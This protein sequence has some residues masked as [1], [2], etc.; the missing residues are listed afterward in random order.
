MSDW[1]TETERRL[2]VVGSCDVAVVGGGI[3]GVA[4]AVAAARNGAKVCL[5]EKESALGGLATLGNVIVYLPLCDG[6]GH[7]VIAGLREELLKLCVRDGYDEIPA[8][9]QRGGPREEREKKRYRVRF[10]PMSYLLALEELVVAS[11]VD[12]HYDTRFCDVQTVAGR[13]NALMVENKS[14]RQALR[15][16]T[17]VDASGDADVCARA[18]ED[19]VSLRT[20]VESAWFFCYDGAEVTLKPLSKSFP[21]DPR[22]A[23]GD[24]RGYA[25]DV[26]ADVT[27]HLLSSRALVRLQLRELQ[28]ASEGK[29]I[30]PLLLP[31]IAS[32]RMTRRLAGRVALAREHERRYFEDTVGMC[33]DWRRPGPIYYLPL[34]SLVGAKHCNLLAAGRC[35]SACGPAWD[36]TRAI[37]VC[38]ATGEAAGT[39][40]ALAARDCGGDVMT[41]DTAQL[42]AQLRRQGVIIDRRFAHRA[43]G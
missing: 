41:L 24:S 37:P 3:A 34:R 5:L 1:I 9:W 36:T 10:N 38:V 14:G 18:G 32:F 35:M 29:R 22:L 15:C 23:P 31:T 19:T 20:N 2:P 6:R 39:A 17:V 42:Q 30:D 33:G 13:V 8:C 40:A 26:A 43:E 16:R 12:L 28:A 7:Q 27:A 4:A 21:E 11:G 25:G